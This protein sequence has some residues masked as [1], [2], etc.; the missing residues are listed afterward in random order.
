MGGALGRSV[1]GEQAGPRE[2][3]AAAPVTPESSA[4]HKANAQ[5][6]KLL[7]PQAAVPTGT[8]GLSP[9][10]T[11]TPCSELEHPA[12]SHGTLGSARQKLGQQNFLEQASE[13]RDNGYLL[14][15]RKI[16]SG[17]FSKVCLAYATRERMRHNARLASDPQAKH[18]AM[19]AIKIIST[20]KAP[21]EF[22]QKFLPHEI[23]SL[24]ATY[25]HLN[26]VQLYEAYQSRGSYLVLELAARGDLLGHINWVSEQCCSPGLDEQEARGLC[27][28]LVSAL[29]HCHSS[30]IVHRDLKCENI[31]LGDRGLLKLTAPHMGDCLPHARPRST[32]T[33]FGFASQLDLKSSLLSTFCG[34]VAYTVPESLMS[35]KYSGEQA[36]LWSLGI[37]LYA[38]VNGK[39]PF[40]EHQPHHV[41][42][43]MRRGPTFRP[44]LSPECQDLIRGL[45]QLRPCARLSLQQ[46]AAHCWMLPATQVPIGTTLRML[47]GGEGRRGAGAGPSA[48]LLIPHCCRLQ[49]PGRDSE[50]QGSAP[51][52]GDLTSRGSTSGRPPE[53]AEARPRRGSGS[54][55]LGRWSARP[56]SLGVGASR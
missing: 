3:A 39:L 50:A 4:W 2:V 5:E 29:A 19:V 53:P 40:K 44:G 55:Q 7:L 24:N 47:P 13:G 16:G 32:R 28:Q 9:A 34:S 56:A 1:N 41:L 23:S 11:P 45:L 8:S 10:P 43:L 49:D 15:P 20:A 35:K 38:M 54:A 42:N 6:H 37:I 46:V 14:S 25:K 21:V 18:L 33:D 12:P 30:G 27:R 52:R 51:C 26:V 31:L 36:D 17:A 22:S 48:P